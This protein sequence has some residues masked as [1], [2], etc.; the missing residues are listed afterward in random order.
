[1]IARPVWTLCAT[2]TALIA[3]SIAFGGASSAAAAPSGQGSANGVAHVVARAE[4]QVISMDLRL[5]RT[6]VPSHGGIPRRLAA[7]NDELTAG[8]AVLA[9]QLQADP[10]TQS[11]EAL[12]ATLA[13][14]QSLK[15]DVA[16]LTDILRRSEHISI[17]DMF[18]MQMLMN[19]LSQMEE[20]S[21]A[22]V[23]ALN[24]AIVAREVKGA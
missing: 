23:S 1:M 10:Q 18:Q 16:N 20:M 4:T 7:I 9:A 11:T 17:G 8:V 22:V 5:G 12:M 19:H 14:I 3:F 13:S 6:F 24:E 2:C 15:A 21:S